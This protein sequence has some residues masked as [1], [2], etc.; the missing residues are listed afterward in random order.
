MQLFVARLAAVQ[1]RYLESS[2]HLQQFMLKGFHEPGFYATGKQRDIDLFLGLQSQ[3]SKELVLLKGLGRQRQINVTH[4]LDSLLEVNAQAIALGRELKT[5]YYKRGF[6]D[7]ALEGEM[8]SYAHFLEDST[9]IS[10][11][12]LLQ[13]RRHEK[14]YMLR[15]NLAFAES[16]SMQMNRTLKTVAAGSIGYRAL[17]NYRNCFNRLVSISEVLGVQ[18]DTGVLPETLSNIKRFGMVY[19]QLL[20]VADKEITEAEDN[21]NFMVLLSTGISLLLTLLLSWFL[22]K[23][24]TRDIKELNS[25]MSGFIQSGFKD[26]PKL[27]ADKKFIPNSREIDQLNRDF[28]LLKVLLRDYLSKINDHNEQLQVQSE[29]LQELNE[30]LQVQSEELRLQSEELLKQQQ[31]EYA[32]RQEAEQ[33]NQAKSVFLATMSH[34]IRTPMNGVLG[35]ATLLHETPLNTEQAEYVETIR[36]SGETLMSVIN[37]VLDFSK[38][39]SGKLELDPHDFDLRYCIEEV[40]DLFA[41][42]AAL[43]GIDLIYQIANDVPMHL[44]ADST[45]LKQVLINLIGNALK[46]THQGE[47][48][49]NVS[50]NHDYR[51]SHLMEL[52]FE[53]T[54]TG[55][56]IPEEKLN[57]LFNAFTQVDSST[58]RKYGGTGLGLAISARLV[59][60]MGGSIVVKSTLG[61]GAC[62]YFSMH[63]AISEQ[64]I[65]H[66]AHCMMTGLGQKRVLV[67]DDNLTNRKILQVQLE[68]WKLLPVMAAS[69]GEAL[70]LLAQRGFDLVITDMQMPEMDGVQLATRVREMNAL[71]PCILLSSV[72]DE[73]RSRYPHLFTAVLT[74]PVKQQQLCKVVQMALQQVSEVLQTEPN[75]TALLDPGFATEH[76]LRIL[77]AEDNQI[78]QKLIIRILNKLGYGPMVAQNGVEVLS[79]MESDTFD[80]ILMD[81]QMPEMDGLEA[82]RIIRL[83]PIH[84]PVIIA[85][86]ANAMLE[87]K[88]MCL[89]A[90]MDD[91]LSKPL[92]IELLLGALSAIRVH[93]GLY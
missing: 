12:D 89:A 23:Y 68:Q 24:L 76:P 28:S 75:K 26:L 55:I 21:F 86:T 25:R 32:A 31:Q 34:E 70:V 77:V 63:A 62:F 74:K 2:G 84:Q 69:A 46:F 14:D 87:D 5:L 72:G 71:L 79:M 19:A 52:A 93:P 38:I 65:R 20:H 1:V 16:F 80:L 83:T 50:V 36:N 91:Y 78:N 40:M 18:K 66:Q 37:D 88:E 13:L 29:E 60:L 8:R 17:I 48:F 3:I 35:M 11:I 4:S 54:D 49:L 9:A 7:Q 64:Q 27:E 59:E 10:K 58:T 43:N 53:V 73:T 30:E 6:Q 39:E 47:I 57:G 92:H 42:K 61:K 51:N 85:M 44:L 15:G 82:T 22:S 67:V 33:A 81:V 41:G 90:G 45:R 56:G